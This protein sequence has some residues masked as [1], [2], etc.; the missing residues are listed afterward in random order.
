MKLRLEAC[1]RC[2][3]VFNILDTIVARAWEHPVPAGRFVVCERCMNRPHRIG[4]RRA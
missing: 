4:R 2:G 1:E 3:Y